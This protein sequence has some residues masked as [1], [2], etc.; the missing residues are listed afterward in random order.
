MNNLLT[1]KQVADRLNIK[2][3]TVYSWVHYK[4]IEYIKLGGKLLFDESKIIELI[5][6]NTV[7]QD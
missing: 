3:S 6:A 2:V 5:K 4:K 1:P 7:K